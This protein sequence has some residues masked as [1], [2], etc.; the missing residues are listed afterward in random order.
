MVQFR[1]SGLRQPL[2]R[3]GKRGSGGAVL[4]ALALKQKNL[5]RKGEHEWL[6][7]PPFSLCASVKNLHPGA[8]HEPSIK[9]FW[10]M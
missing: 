3:T 5:E 1:F 6:G 4:W 2:I 8:E 10:I 9:V 7:H